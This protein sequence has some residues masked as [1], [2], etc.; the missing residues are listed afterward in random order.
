MNLQG[1]WFG[2]LSPGV[3]EAA[4]VLINLDRRRGGFSG[5]A[6]VTS[7]PGLPGE[8]HAIT[9][10]PAANE[11]EVTGHTDLRDYFVIRDRR[12]DII[13]PEKVL[14]HFPGFEPVRH[15]E[16]SGALSGSTLTAIYRQNGQEFGSVECQRIEVAETSAVERK[17]VTWDEFK[18]LARR[19]KCEGAVYRGQTQGWSIRTS[20]HR[21]GRYDLHRFALEDL[22]RLESSIASVLDMTL[23]RDDNE[24]I[25]ALLGIAQHHGFPTPLLDWTKSPY[26]AAY[27]ACRDSLQQAKPDPTIFCFDRESWLRQNDPA[28]DINQALPS[29][30]FIE[31]L[32][33]K[34]ARLLPQQS[35]LVYCNVDDF[36]G[37]VRHR[38]KVHNTSYLTAYSVSDAPGA[39]LRDLRMMGVYAASLFPGLD[40]MCRGVFEDSLESE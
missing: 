40:G 37:F 17:A 27:F 32:P 16:L 29:L 4:D 12:Q 24:H 25:G 14:A 2:K 3:G 31:P 34:N 5:S 36:E 33:L 35:V 21:A 7:R 9:L 13:Q 28:H 19:G 22:R 26:V 6:I 38:E 11:R 8:R 18:A 30:A 20:F 39:V 1:Q 10:Y 23:K 15:A